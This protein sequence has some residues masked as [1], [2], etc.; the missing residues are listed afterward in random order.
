MPW[1]NWRAVP[2]LLAIGLAVQAQP[3]PPL[4]R[5]PRLERPLV[6]KGDLSDPLW[7]QARLDLPPFR[8]YS[9]TRGDILPQDTEVYLACDD[10]HIY[11]GF[12]CRDREPGAIKASLARRDAMWNDDW[13]GLSLDT[14]GSRQ[15]A[16]DLFVNPL[17]IQGDIYDTL[18]GGEDSAPDWVWDSFAKLQ[19]DGYTVEIRIPL[20]SIRFRSGRDVRMGVLFWRRISRLGLSG[21]WPALE[22]GK[23]VFH[24]HVPAQFDELKAPL[25]L[26]LLPSF[27]ASE[28]RA[29]TGPHD[30]SESSGRS[31]GIGMK[32]GLSA[33]TTLELTY[34][35]DFSQVESDAYQVEVNQRYPIF[36]DEKRP[37]FMESMGIFRLAG[38]QGGDTNMQVPV[39]TRRIADPL[40]GAKVTG[41]EG[42]LSYGVLA[43]A[44][45]APGQGWEEGVNPDQGRRAGFTIAR[46]MYGF[47]AANYIGGIA[48]RRSFAG[49]V[50]EVAGADFSVLLDDRRTLSGNLLQTHTRDADPGRSAAGTGALLSL[51]HGG[52]DLD[53]IIVREHY[54]RD[55]RMDT[56]FYNRTGIDQ[57]MLY[58]GPKSYPKLPWA[59]WLQQVNPF[60]F[61][62]VT[63]DRVSG[64]SD[65]L[66]LAALR[67]QTTGQ[68][69]FRADV[70]RLREGWLDRLHTGTS[71]RLQGSIWW[72]KWLSLGG[73]VRV[74]EGLYY[75]D[76]DPFLGRIRSFGVNSTLQPDENLRLGLDYFHTRMLHP[77][78]HREV[79]DVKTFNGQATYQFN[80]YAFL[81]ATGRYDSFK[82][83]L[84][85]DLLASFT[86]I[87]G[88]V[89]HLGYGEV[90]EK[91][92]WRDK[93]FEP[94]GGTLRPT[95]KSLFLKISY[96]WRK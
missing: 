75:S 20:K 40:W 96:L 19:P 85:T 21:S 4:L 54:D 94:G 60:L 5:V 89:V 72:T 63:Q 55:F 44:D 42:R 69:Q 68:G 34:K 27:T 9:P 16:L 41:D 77:V 35:P 13:V 57:T 24:A 28:D 14:F 74:G 38:P 65:Y 81:R 71:Y 64:L 70:M 7:A 90:F 62:T 39:H 46:A 91:G 73:S 11:V 92:D 84:L 1:W 88:T 82:R 8:T 49:T 25:R 95:R 87:P 32:Y 47:G 31:L 50:N 17:G 52:K 36:Y 26:E 48:T 59:A 30:W 12:R 66:A 45:R 56:A 6:L 86:Y 23:S 2:A 93:E 79:Y 15:S 58:V 76:T 10:A 29:R 33:S 67:I 80:R 22:P 78:T 53:A 3:G 18:N 83:R 51:A 43:A 61:G 37:F